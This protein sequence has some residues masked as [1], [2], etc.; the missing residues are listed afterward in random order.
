VL[1]LERG[2]RKS[3]LLFWKCHFKKTGL[4]RIFQ[5][6]SVKAA[7]HGFGSLDTRA[8]EPFLLEIGGSPYPYWVCSVVKEYHGHG[9]CL[10]RVSHWKVLQTSQDQAVGLGLELIRIN[11]FFPSLWNGY[12]P[13][14]SLPRAPFFSLLDF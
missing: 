14:S 9:H 7:R 4:R 3:R 6:A 10:L 12:D 1:F 2:G 11:Q 13:D 8:S 5:G